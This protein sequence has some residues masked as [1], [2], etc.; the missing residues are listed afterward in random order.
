MILLLP[1]GVCT[2]ELPQACG[3]ELDYISV[4]T[5]PPLELRYW[6]EGNSD[7]NAE[8][9]L[10]APSAAVPI[11]T[12]KPEKRSWWRWILFPFRHSGAT[13]TTDPCRLG[14]ANCYSDT[15]APSLKSATKDNS[16]E[17]TPVYTRADWGGFAGLVSHHW[18]EMETSK[19][20][21]TI[22]FGPATIPFIDTGQ[23][24]IRDE[25]GNVRRISGA[26]FVSVLTL[27]DRQR[28]Y[29]KE[30]GAGR[31]VGKPFLAPRK[32]VD[33][34]IEKEIRKK[35][36]FL[37]IPLFNDCRT[38]VCRLKAKLQGKSGVWCYLLFKGYW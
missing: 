23:I 16:E 5:E 21:L 10:T 17:M 38:Y 9:S 13:S 3:A 6:K 15:P 34:V 2:S 37:Y 18:L 28:N 36:A 31:E 14:Y 33:E 11:E 35:G 19:G 8:R 24:G 4:T 26:H 29:A 7:G 1:L 27:P 12:K 30:I 25:Y 22:G 32:R 20:Q